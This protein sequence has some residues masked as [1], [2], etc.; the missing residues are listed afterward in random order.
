[1]IHRTYI[2]VRGG[3]EDEDSLFDEDA[4]DL[5]DDQVSVISEREAEIYDCVTD[6][7]IKFFLSNARSLAP[8]MTALIDYMYEL[9]C[10]FSMITETWFRGGKKLDAELSDIEQASGICVITK[11]RKW[12]GKKA[13]LGG[14][15]AI[16]FNKERCNLKRRAIKSKH[17]ILCVVG[18]I[19]KVTRRI[20]IITVYVP[21]RTK[22]LEFEDICR[23]LGDLV[24]EL[25]ASI[26]NPAIIVAGDFNRRDPTTTLGALDEFVELKSGP[27]RGGARLDAIF[28]N[29]S[30]L[31][32]GGEARVFPPLESEDGRPSD[33][34]C[35]FAAI[36]F[37][38]ARDFEWIKVTVR[39]RSEKRVHDFKADLEGISW[40]AVN[41]M[42]TDGA[43]AAFERTI[44]TLTDL[45][46]PFKTFRRRSNEKPWITNGIR[47]RSRRKRQIFRRRGRLPSWRNLSKDLEKEVRESKEAFVEDAISKGNN[48][49]SFY[50]A[51]KKL[52]GP[53]GTSNWSV[54]ELFPGETSEAICDKV[55]QYFTSVGGT[56]EGDP[57]P[58]GPEPPVDIRFTV[59]DVA[60]MLRALKKKD[61]HVEGDPLP[62]LVRAMPELF[63]VPM[64]TI[65]NKACYTGTWPEKWKIEHITVIPKVKNPG[66]LS[67]TR[68]ISCTS[69]MSKVLEGA[70]L[71]VLR[72]ELEPDPDQYGGIKA[73][74]AEHMLINIWDAV[75]TAMDGGDEAAVLLGIDFQKAFNRME[76]SACIQQLELLGAS[77]GTIG[78]MKSFLR[79][80][81]MKMSLNG[82]TSSP[83][84]ILRG[85]PQ[86]SVMGCALYCATTQLLQKPRQVPR[87]MAVESGPRANQEAQWSPISE[88][89][90]P[91][92]PR[93]PGERLRFFNASSDS[94]GSEDDVRF[95]EVMDSADTE[96]HN[97][98]NGGDPNDENL[99]TFKYIDDTTLVHSVLLSSA[100]RH[101]TTAV[102]VEE[103]DLRALEERFMTLLGNAE[104]IG[105][106]INCSK[107]QLLIMSPNNGCNTVGNLNTPEGPVGSIDTMRLVGFDFG[108]SPDV[109]AHVQSI[110]EKF[111]IRVW[112]LF[113]LRE[114]GIKGNNLFKLFCVYIRSVI[115]YCSPVYHAMLNRGQ[116]GRL[117]GLQRHA[118][119]ICFGYHGDIRALMQEKN[120][121]TLEARRNDRVDSFI[122]KAVNHPR[123]GP[124]WFRLR[125]DSGHDLRGRRHFQ[126]T[127]P[128]TSRAF[129]GPISYF[130]RRANDMGITPG[131]FH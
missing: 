103:L 92:I 6:N 45:H 24:V 76:Y 98:S 118:A 40:E 11:N 99:G 89:A 111:R 42:D 64:A 119:R 15:V 93:A 17:E 49:K 10:D 32:A 113:H 70:L 79:G 112:L 23:D 86:G 31:V 52:S 56:Q 54:T 110:V 71:Q 78:M 107:T 51:V 14:G 109:S 120:M 101:F 58:Y 66:S 88:P 84:T 126:E 48:G 106:K 100:I 4:E 9:Q 60:E 44:T 1:M 20:A 115:E 97:S 2:S 5:E 128:R 47:K 27:T 63:A 87:L 104:D 37:P 96:D 7:V 117:E 122:K 125:P 28:T 80:R 123:F 30:S 130:I 59:S 114:A 124:L 65:F 3:N 102:T 26:K 62:H 36:D 121:R 129:N 67:E 90:L 53:G 19:A 22:V 55:I 29:V 75:L 116:S 72:S 13:V 12:G 127:A 105:M 33:H 18:K 34:G 91:R 38:K 21:P 61:S 39:L 16:A 46:F 43:V 57:V 35:V 83:V 85:S 131:P 81:K 50:A 68:N 41:Q 25:K 82:V 74:G 94:E 8:K 69:L 95:W 77:Q 108:S 73:C